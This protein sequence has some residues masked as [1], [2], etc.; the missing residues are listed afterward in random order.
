MLT[1]NFKKEDLLTSVTLGDSV[2]SSLSI[3]AVHFKLTVRSVSVTVKSIPALRKTN[4]YNSGLW[5]A[6][7]PLLAAPPM[8]PLRFLPQSTH[9]FGGSV[10]SKLI[11]RMWVTTVISS[12]FF[13]SR[14][15]INLWNNK[16]HS[17]AECRW[18]TEFRC[19]LSPRL[20]SED[21][22]SHLCSLYLQ[23]TFI[24]DSH[25]GTR[26]RQTSTPIKWPRAEL[27]RRCWA[28]LPLKDQ[29]YEIKITGVL[30]DNNPAV[31]PWFNPC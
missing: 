8:V 23:H 28:L 25:P 16:K 15:N 29:L 5:Q 19:L 18:R 2:F 6:A 11:S 12:F 10:N 27:Q 21:G 9:A 13:Y 31:Q 22:S 26:T 3:N 30:K 14:L 7:F 20:S 24:Y 4:S 17:S 1:C